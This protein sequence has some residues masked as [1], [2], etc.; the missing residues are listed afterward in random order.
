MLA[1]RQ[2]RSEA[3][4]KRHFSLNST[5]CEMLELEDFNKRAKRNIKKA[6]TTAIFPQE[7]L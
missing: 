5:D 4:K 1:A 7:I 6:I 3:Q 2:H